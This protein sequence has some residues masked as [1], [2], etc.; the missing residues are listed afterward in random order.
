MENHKADY[1]SMYY[2]L[3]GRM[4]GAVE[5]LEITTT[6]LNA[7]TDAL[8]STTAALVEVKEKLK[9]AQ[10]TTEEMFINYEE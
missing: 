9:L 6:A 4:T 5:M 10:Q 1:K 3:A 2:H 8:T 7:A